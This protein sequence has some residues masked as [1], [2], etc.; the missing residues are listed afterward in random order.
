MRLEA[1]TTRLV[2][3]DRYSRFEAI[4]FRLEAKAVGGYEV[5]G[6]R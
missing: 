1:I 6:H 4:A 5:G 3:G 2:G